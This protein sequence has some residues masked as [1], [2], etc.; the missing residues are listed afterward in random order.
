MNVRLYRGFNT[1]TWSTDCEDDN[2]DDVEE[3]SREGNGRAN[4]IAKSVRVF[5][6]DRTIFRDDEKVTRFLIHGCMGRQFHHD[7]EHGISRS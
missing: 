2:D 7:H 1:V 6:D 5:L 4:W 3:K